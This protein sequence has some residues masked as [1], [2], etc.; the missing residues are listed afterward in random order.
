MEISKS[1]EVAD[2][3]TA[4]RDLCRFSMLKSVTTELD[5]DRRGGEPKKKKKAQKKL[6][7]L[8]LSLSRG[9]VNVRGVQLL[10]SCVCV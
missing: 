5:L 7:S 9:E 8:S 10:L 2:C 3:S 1:G 4:P 6:V